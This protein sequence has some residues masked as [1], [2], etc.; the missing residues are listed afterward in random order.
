[1][2][3][4]LHYRLDM[5][6]QVAVKIIDTRKMKDEYQRAN[7]HREA[8]VMAI[9]RHPNIVRLYETLKVIVAIHLVLLDGI[10]CGLLRSVILGVCQS[11]CHAASLC[12]DDVFF[13]STCLLYYFYHNV[14]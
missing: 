5:S 6:L 7:L 10:E 1:V 12:C 9:L 8:R 14:Q 13:P 2:S 11:V 3:E 4:K